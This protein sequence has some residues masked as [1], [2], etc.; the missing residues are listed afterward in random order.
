MNITEPIRR[1]AH[2]TPDAPAILR[3]DGGTIRYGELERGIN[4]MAGHAARLGL[5]AGDIAGID[6][7]PPDE[8]TALI[9]S[10]ALTRIGVA[11]AA[12][13]LPPERLRLC[14]QGVQ[15][16]KL[17]EPGHIAFDASWLEEPAG[18]PEAPA[19][20]MHDAPA[21]LCFVFASSGT[22]GEPKHVPI[23]H[24]LMTRRIFGRWLGDGGGRDVRLIALGL[25][26]SWGFVTVLRTLWMGGT[27]ALSDPRNMGSTIEKHKI[28]SVVTSPIALR[29]I[30]ESRP[31]DSAP[32]P[33]LERVEV[34]GSV[35]PARLLEM[36]QTR[37]CP[38]IV[39]VLGSAENGGTASAPI[40]AL[41]ARPGAV[42]YRFPGVQ[43]EAVD[44]EGAPLPPGSAGMLRIRGDMVAP[45]YLWNE[46][47]TAARFRDGW[48]HSDDIGTVW[49][50]GM[51]SLGGRGSEIINAGGDKISP[52]TIEAKLRTLPNVTD[53]AAFGVPDGTGIERVW[54][55]IIADEPIEDA[56]LDAFCDRFPSQA[57]P[58]IILQLRELPYNAN[59]KLDRARLVALGVEMSRQGTNS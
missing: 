1:L 52:H 36:A 59:G 38:N 56:L 32:V 3:A 37:L 40:S 9:L 14:F 35:L 29:T 21:A 17:L 28:S 39:M 4:R 5:R 45:G 11:C 7:L 57:G 8:A 42:G 43:V 26:S 23:S 30:V 41:A 12:T 53:A 25:N 47:E 49:P 33:T 34:G 58:E 13:R 51:I 31:P 54:A 16:G 15:P 6:I 46:A 19:A 2:L 24:E 20:A 44:E 48:F 55:A 22:T 27:L 10:L 18:Q 50:D